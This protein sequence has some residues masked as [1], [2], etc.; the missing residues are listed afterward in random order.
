MD[1]VSASSRSHVMASVK[2]KN[3]KPELIVRKAIFREGLRF[4]LHRRDLP[5]RPDLVLPKFNATI[6]VNGCFW[7]FHGCKKTRTPVT[8]QLYWLPKLAKNKERD[9]RNYELLNK[10]GW[11]VLVVWECYIATNKPIVIGHEVK[12]WLANSS[13]EVSDFMEFSGTLCMAP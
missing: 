12:L 5:G 10:L 3:T 9:E 7:H 13:V 11:R 4:Q 2:G 1:R 8:N 6:F